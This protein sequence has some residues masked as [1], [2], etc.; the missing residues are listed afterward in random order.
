VKQKSRAK[1][2]EAY[3]EGHIK[4]AQKL[5]RIFLRAT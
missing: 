2:G 1:G 4:K 5:R 3:V